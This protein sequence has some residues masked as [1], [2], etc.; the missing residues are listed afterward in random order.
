MAVTITEYSGL[1]YASGRSVPGIPQEP[2][3]A[4]QSFTVA[5][6]VS[7]NALTAAQTRLVRIRVDVGC[8]L[9]FGSSGSTTIPSATAINASAYAPGEYLRGVSPYMRITSLST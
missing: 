6:T 9:L 7:T 3:L 5:G 8:F 2:A 4:V 1:A